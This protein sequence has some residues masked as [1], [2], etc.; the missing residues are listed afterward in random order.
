MTKQE[1]ETIE[2]FANSIYPQPK[3]QRALRNMLEIF[4]K[5]DSKKEQVWQWRYQEK[6][7]ESWQVYYLLMTEEKASTI[8]G[9]ADLYVNNY[10]KH[11]GPFEVK[12]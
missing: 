4:K 12:E 7:G 6:A 1:L 8:F 11:L 9:P 5:D 3:L 10:E 2:E